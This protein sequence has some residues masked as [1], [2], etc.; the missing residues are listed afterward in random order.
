MVGLLFFGALAI[1]GYFTIVSDNG[2]FAPKGEQMVFFFDN[3]DGVKAGSRVTVLGV[4]AGTVADISLVAVDRYKRPLPPD[5]PEQVGQRVA[6]TIELK[7]PVVFYENYNIAVKNESLL[8]GKIIAIDPGSARRPGKSRRVRQLSVRSVPTQQ[9]AQK[10]ETALQSYFSARGP[11]GPEVPP[12]DAFPDLEGETAG[13]PLAGLAELISE[14]REGIRQTID[15]VAEIT[16]KINNGEGTVGRLI[17]DDDLHRN[18]DSLLDD[19][20]V[21]IKELRESLEDTREQAPVTS[22]IRAALT[23]F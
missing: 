14:N 5:S 6:I 23:A 2:P 1:V 17:N 16:D 8:S 12:S 19:A 11:V 7:Q 10:G 3:A 18:A 22:F 9:L 4:P 13:D 20:Q 15:N 21:V